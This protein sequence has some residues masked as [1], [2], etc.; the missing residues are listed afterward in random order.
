M[1]VPDLFLMVYLI[2]IFLCLLVSPKQFSMRS[3]DI[4]SFENDTLLWKH[5]L[6]GLVVSFIPVLNTFVFIV[7]ICFYI[8]LILEYIERTEILN[9]E[10]FKNKR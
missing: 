9:I 7:C 10:V 5:V 4:N 6:L 2:S 8:N 1:T 3:I